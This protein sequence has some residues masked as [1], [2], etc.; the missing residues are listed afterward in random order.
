MIE[1]LRIKEIDVMIE[2]LQ[3]EMQRPDL[4]AIDFE[5]KTI[6]TKVATKETIIPKIQPSPSNIPEPEPTPSKEIQIDP[7][8][9]KF[10]QL[11]AN[12]KDRNS[13]LGL[14]FES[15][16]SFISYENDTLTW[17]SCPD[18]ECKKTLK[19]GYPAIKQ[20]VRE[21]FDFNT[22]I[23]H[24]ACSKTI[25]IPIQNTTQEAPPLQP[26]MTEA[27][28]SSMIEDAE[29]GGSASCVTSCDSPDNSKEIDSKNIKDE[30]MV[31]KAIELFEANKITIQ[32][33][34]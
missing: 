28:S 19:H 29:I 23:K 32:S 9:S 16:I 10:T 3:K 15:S 33:K 4:G 22:K 21:E 27:Q 6:T 14:C 30:P 8:L 34:I 26:T 7:N 24:I 25:A 18:E 17:E 20:L 5:P 1:A 11:I 12:I 31:A 13:A 2:S